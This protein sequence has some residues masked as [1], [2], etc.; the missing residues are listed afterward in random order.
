MGINAYGVTIWETG[1]TLQGQGIQD[2][3]YTNGQIAVAYRP[4]YKVVYLNGTG[5]APFNSN[6]DWAL[7]LA[8]ACAAGFL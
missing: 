7:L 8:N 3:S 6:G 5:H 2:A 4:D 1:V